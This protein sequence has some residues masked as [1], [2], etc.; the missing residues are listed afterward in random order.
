ML[1]KV[2]TAPTLD[3]ARRFAADKVVSAANRWRE[4][5]AESEGKATPVAERTTG[6]V[7]AAL[8]PAGIEVPQRGHVA[9]E[10][11]DG[12]LF[13]GHPVTVMVKRNGTPSS[14][15]LDV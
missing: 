5:V 2:A 6:E 10:F 15:E 9:I 7:Y 12:Y 3:K 4:D 8:S 14:V 13:G 11:D 1:G